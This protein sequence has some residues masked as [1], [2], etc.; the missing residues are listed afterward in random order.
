M[1]L[2]YNIALTSF[3][4]YLMSDYESIDVST[5]SLLNT[6][7][8]YGLILGEFVFGI[9]GDGVGRSRA[10]QISASLMFIATIL[11]AFSGVVEIYNYSISLQFASLR[12]LVGVGAGGML[13]L[14]ATIT[15]ESS[16]RVRLILNFIV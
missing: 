16:Q 15:R 12:F 4:I 3:I 6:S 9:L 5:L 11:S 1:V 7:I 13:P 8:F 2:N 14:V 10:F